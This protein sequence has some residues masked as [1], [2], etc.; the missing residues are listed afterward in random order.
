MSDKAEKARYERE[1]REHDAA[2][3]TEANLERI[4]DSLE[5]AVIA[6]DSIAT[7]LSLQILKTTPTEPAMTYSTAECIIPGTEP[8]TVHSTTRKRF[9]GAHPDRA[10]VHCTDC[11]RFEGDQHKPSC[12]R[13]G[14]V[15]ATSDYNR[16]K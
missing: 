13:Q 9:E 15:T 7:A 4:A 14:I 2:I 5:R 11:K 1:Q 16:Q 10:L 3:N 12:H 6:L 8:K